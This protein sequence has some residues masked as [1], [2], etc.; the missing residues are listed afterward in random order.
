M[1]NTET[2][3]IMVSYFYKADTDYGTR[4]AKAVGADL[5]AVQAK[6]AQL[7]DE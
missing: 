5:K 2:K 4:L 6:A 7:K 3:T 1:K